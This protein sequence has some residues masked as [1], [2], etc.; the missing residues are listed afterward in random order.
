MAIQWF[1][2]HMHKARKDIR[3]VMP[4]VDLVIEVLDARIPFSSENP[5]ISEL[6]AD[7]PC[8]KILNKS[9]LADPEPTAE[10]QA[11]LEKDRRVRTLATRL[12]EPDGIRRLTGLCRQ[13]FPERAEDFRPIHTMIMG[14]PNVGK[15]SIINVLA[16]RTIAKTGNEP[17][18]TKNRQKIRL[19]NGITLSDT[20]GVLW[21][22]VENPDSGYRLALTGAIRDTAIDHTDVAFF[23]AGYFAANYP[24]VLTERFGLDTVP[25]SELEVMEAIGRKRGCLGAGGLVDLDRV[26]KIL[27]TEYRSGKLGR[28]TL[29][30]PEM[31]ARELA[32]VEKIRQEKA[33]KKAARKEKR[34]GRK[35]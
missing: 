28:L 12:D 6:R 4:Q 30:T 26:A 19:D 24:S 14:I 21:P 20:P 29:E 35:K 7:K 27:I 16:G 11:F 25:V 13:M 3:Q 33:E 17:A 32:N 31:M 22:N 18:V 5:M 8:V 2:G 34:G 15:S 1:P 23:A 10:W 9:D